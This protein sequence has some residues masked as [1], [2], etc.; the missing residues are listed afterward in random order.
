MRG[1]L[2]A[3]LIFYAVPAVGDETIK[4]IPPGEDVIE[5]LP[6][7]TPA[8]FDGQL[9]DINTSLRWANWL[10]QYE[11]VLAAEIERSKAACKAELEYQAK[12]GSIDVERVTQL[13]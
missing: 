11:A 13:N 5:P 9:F 7:G 6:K 8:P 2:L 1:L 3:A 10:T 12:V 4:D